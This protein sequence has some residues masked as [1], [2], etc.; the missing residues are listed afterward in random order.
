M[1]RRVDFRSAVATGRGDDGMTGLLFDDIRVQKDDLRTEAFG[2]VDEAVSALGL[3]R[4]ELAN[5][6]SYGAL[7]PNFGGLGDLILRIQREL[8]VAGAELATAPESRGKQTDGVSRISKQ[9]LEGVEAVSRLDVPSQRVLFGSHAP[10]FYFESAW[11]KL[12]ESVLSDARLRALRA[13][14]IA[15]SD[16]EKMPLIATSTRMTSK[17]HHGKGVSG[18][19]EAGAPFMILAFLS[20]ESVCRTTARSSGVQAPENRPD[21]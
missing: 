18:G 20:R 17:S 21:T 7:S 10:L 2:T 5:K 4:A 9:M 1:S 13:D 12:R 16:I 19:R 14:T 6:D 15:S 3:A 11:L 8:F